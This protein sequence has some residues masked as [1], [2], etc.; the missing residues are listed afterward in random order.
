MPCPTAR[1][2][3]YGC[4]QSVGTP[5]ANE[6]QP[7]CMRC[8]RGTLLSCWPPCNAA[9]AAGHMLCR[10]SPSRSSRPATRGSSSFSSLFK[11]VS[12]AP[13][14]LTTPTPRLQHELRVGGW[15]WVQ[16]DLCGHKNRNRSPGR[17]AGR[18]AAPPLAPW[19]NCQCPYAS[20][21]PPCSPSNC[22]CGCGAPEKPAPGS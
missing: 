4:Q 12:T 9:A 17:Q 8:C 5:H 13:M 16:S 15:G 20:P 21:S 7:A 18:R 14:I 6:A 10:C 3:A 19:G 11:A 2:P 1:P 22:A